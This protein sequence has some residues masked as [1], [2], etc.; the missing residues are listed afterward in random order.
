M[1]TCVW[2]QGSFAV[3][4]L[5]RFGEESVQFVKCSVEPYY[6]IRWREGR[7]MRLELFISSFVCNYVL[8]EDCGA[9]YGT[10]NSVGF[11][12]CACMLAFVYISFCGF[13]Q[14]WYIFMSI[15]SVRETL[16]ISVEIWVEF[17]VIVY[18]S[19]RPLALDE[20]QAVLVA[21]NLPPNVPGSKTVISKLPC[22]M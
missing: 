17:S 5:Q 10:V 19:T 1:N 22:R 8:V 14:C 6:Q 15:C 3:F 9:G 16:L 13:F 2:K 4:F 18:S 20:I 12:M 21:W 7:Q 11:F